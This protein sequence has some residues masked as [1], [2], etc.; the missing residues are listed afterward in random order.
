MDERS[1]RNIQ[2]TEEL[3][4]LPKH[5]MS[6]TAIRAQWAIFVV[7]RL[8]RHSTVFDL[9]RKHLKDITRGTNAID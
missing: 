6:R 7:R 2:A 8:L 1:C 4:M 5:S 9:D 3:K